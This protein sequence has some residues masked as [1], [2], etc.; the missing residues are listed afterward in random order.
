MKYNQNIMK[1]WG[2][3]FV[4]SSFVLKSCKKVL[5]SFEKGTSNCRIFLNNRNFLIA[6]YIAYMYV[7]TYTY[8]QIE[9]RILNT[10]LNYIHMYVCMYVKEKK[11]KTK[12]LV[13]Q[14]R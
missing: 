1:Q 5:K 12:N 11:E 4:Y 8:V 7:R 3:F 13:L 2:F 9:N 14:G 6:Y 10:I